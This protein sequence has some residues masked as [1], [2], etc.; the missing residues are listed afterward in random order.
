MTESHDSPYSVTCPDTGAR[1]VVCGCG[2]QQEDTGME[3]LKALGWR[4]ISKDWECPFC[5]ESS[6]RE[7]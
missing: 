4:I 1:I 3:A 7:A 2:R 5:R 6:S